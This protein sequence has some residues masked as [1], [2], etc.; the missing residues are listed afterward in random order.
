MAAYSKEFQ[1]LVHDV[2]PNL[3]ARPS[4]ILIY[5]Q[6]TA[7]LQMHTQQPSYGQLF[8]EGK[9]FVVS[10][11]VVKTYEKIM[12][13]NKV[14]VE[15]WPCKGSGVTF[16]R[17]YRMYRGE[18]LVAEAS[19]VWALIDRKERTFL[20]EKDIDM[21]GYSFGEEIP[22]DGMRFVLPKIPFQKVGEHTVGFSEIDCND[23]M[24]NTNYPDILMNVLPELNRYYVSE[25]SIRYVSEAKLLERFDIYCS[26]L[27]KENEDLV[28]YLKT[29]K[30]TGTNVMARVVVKEI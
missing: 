12:Q 27:Q 17:C 3:I 10:R 6:E 7:N 8:L 28:Y 4:S 20:S 14:R 23:H 1:I 9:I 11:M 16:K 29:E 22:L 15:S 21:S 18:Q 13:Y 30:S 24:N 26:E 25:F 19:S 5:L 2:G